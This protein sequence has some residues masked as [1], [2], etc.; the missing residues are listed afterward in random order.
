[1]SGPAV[2]VSVVMP[3]G[4]VDEDLAAQLDTM[5]G[6]TYGEPWELI[7]SLNTDE[8]VERALGAYLARR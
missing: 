1:M 5:A 7:C 6:Q 8:P 3:V 4:R 2:T